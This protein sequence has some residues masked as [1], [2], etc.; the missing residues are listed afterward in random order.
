MVDLQVRPYIVFGLN[1]HKFALNVASVTEIMAVGPVNVLPEMPPHLLGLFRF[2]G[3]VV[4]LVDLK[5]RL[6]LTGRTK[7]LDTDEERIMIVNDNGKWL[8]LKVDIIHEIVQIQESQLLDYN[9]DDAHKHAA[10]DDVYAL[11]SNHVIVLRLDAIVDPDLTIDLVG[12]K[13]TV[14]MV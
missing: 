8:G 4:P 1:E 11:G 6:G 13:Q 2:R 14:G 10:V 7:G 3:Q 12:W 5:R 9:N